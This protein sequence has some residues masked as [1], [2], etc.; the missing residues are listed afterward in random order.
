MGK[1][2]LLNLYETSDRIPFDRGSKIVIISDIHRGDGSYADSL[3][4]NKSI[5]VAALNYYFKEK[6]T[7][8]EAGD[9][10]EL[11]KNK[12]YRDIAYSYKDIF[13]SLNKFN[14]D[15]RLY[16]IY[17]NHDGKKSSREFLEKQKKKLRKI[18][19]NFGEDLIYLID[20]IKFK[21]GLVLRYLPMGKEIMVTHGHQLDVMNYEFAS[22][23]KFLVRHVWRFMEGIAGFKSPTSPANNY[24]KGGII[25]IKLEEWA[26]E[27]KK[28]L[29]CGHTHRSRFPSSGEGLYFNDG[30]CVLPY[31]IS[32]IEIN[33]GLIALVKWSIAVRDDNSLYI[34]RNIIGGPERIE[35]YL[36][37]VED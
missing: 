10:D 2:A 35:E 1:K 8:I 13:K 29:I 3:I 7:L 24:K 14:K 23:S 16:L 28:L 27:N 25:D 11:W 15:K 30:C 21:E 33:S 12:C 31:S 5:Y 22:I 6:Y 34:K 37:Y 4:G 18:G 26:K 20:N 32:S 36:K 17:G 9:G 19:V